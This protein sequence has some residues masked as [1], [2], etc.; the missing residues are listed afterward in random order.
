[1]ENLLFRIPILIKFIDGS[2]KLFV[3]K[4]YIYIFDKIKRSKKW[5]KEK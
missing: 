5:K 2:F 4:K 1:V 3:F